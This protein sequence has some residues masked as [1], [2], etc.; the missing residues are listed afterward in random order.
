MEV[1]LEVLLKKVEV[2]RSILLF[3]SYGIGGYKT[4]LSIYNGFT[5][6]NVLCK[7]I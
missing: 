5:S 4:L 7:Q 3:S 1:C 6:V 2:L